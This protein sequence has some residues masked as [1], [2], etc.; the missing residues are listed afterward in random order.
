MHIWDTFVSHCTWTVAMRHIILHEP[1]INP[2]Q[3]RL[4]LLPHNIV[5]VTCHTQSMAVFLCLVVRQHSCA[6]A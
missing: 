3:R 2:L 5:I 1:V 4:V 6:F